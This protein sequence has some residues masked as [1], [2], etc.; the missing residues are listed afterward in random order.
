MKRLLLIIDPQIDFING[1]LPVPEAIPKMERLAAYI[2]RTDGNMRQKQL[3]WIG[4]RT[5]IAHLGRM[6]GVADAL[7][8]EYNRRGNLSG[9]GGTALYDTR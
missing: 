3:H 5:I 1:T 6:V 4:I 9:I 7:R 2:K 8:T